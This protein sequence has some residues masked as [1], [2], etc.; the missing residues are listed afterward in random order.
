MRNWRICD[1]IGQKTELEV[2][3]MKK[4]IVR[5]SALAMAGLLL[6]PDAGSG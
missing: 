5:A 3:A 1:T 6:V 2:F 4:M